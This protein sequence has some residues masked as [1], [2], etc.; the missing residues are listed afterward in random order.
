MA[1]RCNLHADIATASF[2]IRV[3]PPQVG[4]S[5]TPEPRV[6]LG[7]KKQRWLV[8]QQPWKQAASPHACACGWSSGPD[9]LSAPDGRSWLWVTTAPIKKAVLCLR[10]K[11]SDGVLGTDAPLL[12]PLHPG[13]LAGKWPG[14]VL[15]CTVDL[16]TLQETNGDP[17]RSASRAPVELRAVWRRH[18]AS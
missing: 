13:C 12:P 15:C 11:T 14:P 2:S 5:T 10:P 16:R 3:L 1:F 7:V 9:S 6:I 17:I 8:A 18:Q 4:R